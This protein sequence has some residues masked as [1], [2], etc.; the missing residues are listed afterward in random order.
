MTGL[1]L[2][3]VLLGAAQGIVGG[4]VCP[5]DGAAL[6]ERPREE[7]LRAIG[8]A[9]SSHS[10]ECLVRARLAAVWGAFWCERPLPI[11]PFAVILRDSGVIA[12]PSFVSQKSTDG[13]NEIKRCM[14]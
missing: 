14:Q 10:E 4:A 3:I 8:E 7:R 13:L 2:A 5:V 6:S 9:S 12:A 1:P 11:P